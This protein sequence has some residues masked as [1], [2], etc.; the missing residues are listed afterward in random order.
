[1]TM[2]YLIT[3]KKMTLLTYRSIFEMKHY[4]Q[5]NVRSLIYKKFLQM[6]EYR[7]SNNK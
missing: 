7:S 6:L 4:V 1:M 5:Y 3:H 2:I